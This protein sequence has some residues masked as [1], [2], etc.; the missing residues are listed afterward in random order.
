VYVRDGGYG[1]PSNI[2]FIGNRFGTSSR[3]GLSSFDGAVT[4]ENNTWADTGEIINASGDVIGEGNP[5]TT[6]TTNAPA[7]PPPSAGSDDPPATG[8][9]NPDTQDV[10][11]DSS[12]TIP[13]IVSTTTTVASPTTTLASV[14]TTTREVV[15]L[16]PSPQPPGP[17]ATSFRTETAKAVVVV[18]VVLTV[19]YL[20]SMYALRRQEA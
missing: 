20:A 14:T 3:Y 8:E 17:V 9:G 4:W 16:A 1:M 18:S 2:S 7:P 6:T 12:G 11:V 15:A 5:T 10:M 13:Q 19:L